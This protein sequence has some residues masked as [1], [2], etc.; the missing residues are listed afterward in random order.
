MVGREKFFLPVRHPQSE[1][2]TDIALALGF[3][4]NSV[5]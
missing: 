4:Y 1:G 2:E 3:L 5:L